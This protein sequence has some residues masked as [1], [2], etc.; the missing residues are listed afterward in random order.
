MRVVGIVLCLLVASCGR[1]GSGGEPVPIGF[2]AGSASSVT[3]VLTADAGND[4]VP[5]ASAS[6]PTLV[7]N[8]TPTPTS[9]KTQKTYC[10]NGL[11]AIPQRMGCHCGDDYT[12]DIEAPPPGPNCAMHNP[13][14]EGSACIWSCR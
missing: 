1:R 8:P 6:G 14:A 9:A 3:I 5:S 2:D 10:P 4:G 11:P 13:R 7:R 12:T